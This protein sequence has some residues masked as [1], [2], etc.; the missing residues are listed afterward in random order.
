MGDDNSLQNTPGTQEY[1]KVISCDGVEFSLTT[2]VADEC[3][4]F[5]KAF[6]DHF[7]EGQTKTCTLG[8]IK[9]DVLKKVVDYLA[10]KHSYKNNQNEIPK[11]NVEDGIVVD[12]LL[13]AYY[14]NI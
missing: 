2:E 13:A 8:S 1:V 12:L 14:L 7:L 3:E 11:F 6:S 5:R 10:F 9:G 4:Y